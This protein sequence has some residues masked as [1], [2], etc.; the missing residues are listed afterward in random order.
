MYFP[1]LCWLIPSLYNLTKHFSPS[2]SCHVTWHSPDVSSPRC[3]VYK[4][5]SIAISQ[6]VLAHRKATNP[7]TASPT[8]NSTV[9]TTNT[10]WWTKKSS[11]VIP[12]PLSRT[13]AGKPPAGIPKMEAPGVMDLMEVDAPSMPTCALN[14]EALDMALDEIIASA[15]G[16]ERSK[17]AA[18]G[19]AVSTET[20]VFGKKAAS[21][22]RGRNSAKVRVR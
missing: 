17:S 9:K 11:P 2:S 18:A 13:T 6:S 5:G 10:S 15:A 19:Q 3:A 12:D 14:C 8:H 20:I 21:S 4:K 7:Q 1:V 16:K 22:R